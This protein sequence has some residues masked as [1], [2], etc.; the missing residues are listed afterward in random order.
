[1][2]TVA[3]VA[4]ARPTF[5]VEQAQANLM[6]ARSLLLELGATLV[7]PDSLV[8]T[9]DDLAAL[10]LPAADLHILFMA[11]F[12][13]ASA[14]VEVFG[15]VPGPIIGWSMREPGEVGE[16]LKLNSMCGV[17]LAAH[18][19]LNVGQTLRHIHGNADEAHVRQ[20]LTDAL[21]GKMPPIKMPSHNLGNLAPHG[22]VEKALEWLRGK[23]IGAVG[24]APTGFTPCV[25]DAEQLQKYFGLEVRQIGIDN[26]FERISKVSDDVRD[27]TYAS[28]VAAQPSL[29]SVNIDEAK[30]VAGVE[31]ALDDWRESD[32]L[33]AIAIRCWP[34]FP[35][36]LGACI[37]SSLGRLSDRGTVTTC[38]RDVLGA[39]TMLVCEALGSDENYLV[40]IVDLDEKENLVRLWHCGSAATKLAADPSSATQYIHC[41]RKLG[42]AGN[43]PL[44]TGP[45]TLFRIDRDVDDNNPTGL[46]IILSSGE[47]IPAPN[48]FQGNTA[49]VKTSVKADELVNGIITGGYPHHLVISWIDVRPGI[50]QLA[51]SLGIPITEW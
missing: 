31:V 40:D 26:A 30:K 16:R 22:E 2:S 1:M 29:A 18:A 35:T 27:Q 44:K 46:R 36:D 14:A 15:G 43:F 38:E 41:N 19:L 3:L 37:C 28:A 45:V 42:V 17:N 50:R 9:V 6:S 25:Y 12:A 33:D 34:E 23:R 48:R 49:T 7:G 21:A 24:E 5:D 13:D 39:V 11:S 32:A 47:S 51:Q 10:S 4:M 20:A 8:M